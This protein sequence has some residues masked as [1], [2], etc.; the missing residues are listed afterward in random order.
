[1]SVV[2]LSIHLTSG[3]LSGHQNIHFEKKNPF[4]IKE[5]SDDRIFGQQTIEFHW[6]ILND[7]EIFIK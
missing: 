1:M 2:G 5:T 7:F 6:I 3:Q 4:Q